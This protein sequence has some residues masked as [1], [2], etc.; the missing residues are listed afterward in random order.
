MPVNKVVVNA[1]F[2]GIKTDRTGGL[3]WHDAYLAK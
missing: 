2:Q 3:L 1:K